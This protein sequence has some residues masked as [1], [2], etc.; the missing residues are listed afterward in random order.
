[1]DLQR[2]KHIPDNYGFPPYEDDDSQA[3]WQDVPGVH[4]KDCP[5]DRSKIFAFEHAV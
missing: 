4:L 3:S 5:H 2:A 1:M